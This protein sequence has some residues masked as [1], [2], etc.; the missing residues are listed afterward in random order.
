MA[1]TKKQKVFKHYESREIAEGFVE[2]YVC[3]TKS[4]VMSESWKSLSYSS[5]NF[6]IYMKFWSY[7]KQEFT[8]SYN[9]AMEVFHSRTTIKKCIDELVDKGFVE[10]TRISKAPNV[11]TKY[12]FI[13]KWYRER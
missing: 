1:R 13:D 8:Y 5:K 2:P 12:K 9:L 7:G 10:I 3:L 11:G 6:Y 4:M